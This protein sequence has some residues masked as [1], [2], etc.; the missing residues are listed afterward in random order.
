MEQGRVLGQTV[1]A[2]LVENRVLSEDQ[3]S[4]AIA[5][6]HGLDHVDLDAFDVDLNVARLISRQAAQRYR[7]VPIGFDSEGALIVALADPVD[8]LAVSDIGVMTK[9]QVRPMVAA[10][11]AIKEI[12][13]RLPDTRARVRPRTIASG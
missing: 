3:L 12:I 13:E 6:F 9:S 4:R 5:E 11:S 10:E 2:V 8:P 7:A 1:G